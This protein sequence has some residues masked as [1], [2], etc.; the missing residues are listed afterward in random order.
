ML[1]F[2][3]TAVRVVQSPDDAAYVLQKTKGVHWIFTEH[4]VRKGSRLKFAIKN[5]IEKFKQITF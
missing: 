2:Y 4:P 5:H 3:A 1:L